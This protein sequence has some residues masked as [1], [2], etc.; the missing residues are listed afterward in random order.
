MW[1]LRPGVL[2]RSTVGGVVVLVPGVE[3]PQRLQ[4]A[5]EEA[6][7]AVVRAAPLPDADAATA[8][9]AALE[10][11]GAVVADDA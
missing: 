11:L 8:A 1:R 5:A 10:R 9:V 2:W 7:W 4:G 3:H 6:W